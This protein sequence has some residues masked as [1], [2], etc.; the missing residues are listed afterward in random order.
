MICFFFLRLYKKGLKPVIH[1]AEQ[2]GRFKR[3]CFGTGYEDKI[4]AGRRKAADIVVEKSE[5]LS[6]NS[7]GTVSCNRITDFLA[8][9]D[10]QSVTASVILPK[11][12]DETVVYRGFALIEQ[13][14]EFTIILD[15]V[16][17]FG[18]LSHT[19]LTYKLISM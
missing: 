8:G 4:I 16:K 10:T 13:E 3:S 11:I 2:L 18:I 7:T 14:S 12:T 17:P 5:S 6:Y 9:N 1:K 19:I 15:T